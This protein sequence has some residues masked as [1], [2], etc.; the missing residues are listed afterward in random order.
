LARCAPSEVSLLRRASCSVEDTEPLIESIYTDVTLDQ[1]LVFAAIALF[2]PNK[3]SWIINKRIRHVYEEKYPF[4]KASR[5]S[6]S[7]SCERGF[8]LDL[9]R[10]NGVKSTIYCFQKYQCFKYLLLVRTSFSDDASD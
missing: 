8:R 1:S 3:R 9:K 4:P 7:T 10:R 5:K 6:R 2:E